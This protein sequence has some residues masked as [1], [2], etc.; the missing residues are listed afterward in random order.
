MTDLMNTAIINYLQASADDAMG[1][2][3]GDRHMC[4]EAKNLI[5]DQAAT[6][7]R[8]TEALETIKNYPVDPWGIAEKALA[9]DTNSSQCP[10]CGVASKT[11]DLHDIECPAMKLT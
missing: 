7:T 1:M 11:G 4:N 10:D 6:I 8:L 3:A 9:V 2:D 5:N